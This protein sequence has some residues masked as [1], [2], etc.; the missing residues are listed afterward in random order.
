[1][2]I[3]EHKYSTKKGFT[4]KYNCKLLVFFE[5]HYAMESAIHREKRIKAGTRDKKVQLIEESNPDWKD[6]YDGIV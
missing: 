4:A 5:M 2:G 3:Y 6:L 1:M